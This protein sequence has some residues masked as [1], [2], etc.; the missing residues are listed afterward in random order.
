VAGGA[1]PRSHPFLE[2]HG[3]QVWKPVTTIGRA[4]PQIA[5]SR[6]CGVHARRR[7]WARLTRR[8]PP[9]ARAR[10]LPETNPGSEWPQPGYFIA[11]LERV[12]KNPMKIGAQTRSNAWLKR[13]GTQVW[14]PA[15][16]S[17]A[18]QQQAGKPAL[19]RWNAVVS[20]EELLRAY[21]A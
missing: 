2:G 15:S 5:G 7:A 16:R 1:H 13:H 9:H 21:S 18:C 4:N 12:A 10:A 20:A 3:T 14:K 8:Q 19:R 6:P 11:I 17:S